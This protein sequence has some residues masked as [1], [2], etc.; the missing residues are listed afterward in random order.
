MLMASEHRCCGNGQIN[1]PMVTAKRAQSAASFDMFAQHCNHNVCLSLFLS[2]LD[3]LITTST[4]I[5]M[6]VLILI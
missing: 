5:N 4:V 1:L 6:I 2:L 3:P